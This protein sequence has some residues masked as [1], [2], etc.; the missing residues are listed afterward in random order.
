VNRSGYRRG[1]F[2]VVS[3]TTRPREREPGARCPE[4]RRNIYIF[5]FFRISI[6]SEKLQVAK[7][8]S[9]PDI[10]VYYRDDRFVKK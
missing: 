1:I 6:L 9:I 10:I 2:Q 5:F 4:G 7:C 8:P 3:G